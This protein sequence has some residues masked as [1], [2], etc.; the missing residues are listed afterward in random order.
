MI[1]LQN[2]IAFSAYVNRPSVDRGKEIFKRFVRAI[3]VFF[4]FWCRDISGTSGGSDR[5]LH[6]NL[7]MRTVGTFKSPPVKVYFSRP[8]PYLILLYFYFIIL[9]FFLNS[10]LLLHTH[11]IY[12]L[13]HFTSLYFTSLYLNTRN[14]TYNLSVPYRVADWHPV[15]IIKTLLPKIHN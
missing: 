3:L 5:S 6:E 7:S 15:N 9:N 14:F 4:E 13:L 10:Q 1:Y 12:T 8:K 11:L 2:W